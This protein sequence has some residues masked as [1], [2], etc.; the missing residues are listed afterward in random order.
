[1]RQKLPESHGYSLLVND[2]GKTIHP[3]EEF[4]APLLVPGCE[5]LEKPEKGKD[6]AKG[7]GDGPGDAP[8][9]DGKASGAEARTGPPGK[10]AKGTRP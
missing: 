1:M 7:D 6:G 3:G 10:Q 8:T 5:S 4:D 9:G 2:I